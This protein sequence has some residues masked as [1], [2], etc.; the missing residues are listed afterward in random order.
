MNPYDFVRLSAGGPERESV[1]L[2]D[3]FAGLSGRIKCTL[4]GYTPIFIPRPRPESASQG[5]ER[6]AMNR[7]RAGA[8]MLP[9]TSLKGVIRNVAEAASASCF[10][11]PDRLVYERSTVRYALPNAKYQRCPDD[12]GRLCP[13]CRLFGV[14]NRGEVFSGNVTV[15][16]GVARDGYSLKSFTLAVLGAPK[17]RHTAFYAQQ[18][19]G[20]AL[21]VA[22]RKFYFH[23]PQGPLERR[24]QDG[25]NKTVEAVMP[26]AVF[27]F[28]LEYSNLHAADLNL[29]LFALALWDDTCHKIGMGK[30][31]G[32]GSAKL[33]IAE[34]TTLNRSARYQ[35]LNGGWGEAMSDAGLVA[36]VD[37]SVAPFRSS[38]APNLQD[39]HR[40]LRWNESAPD[41]IR[42][43]D[44]N[45]FLDHSREPL[46]SAP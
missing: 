12:Q 21:I 19:V 9:G 27:D 5:H 35:T 10:T 38:T 16:D 41:N 28:E 34:V 20:K 44:R 37:A 45:W 13:A 36:W 46:S 7:N 1:I 24:L 18:P 33:R 26:G 29:L 14:L 43:P 3:R 39:L 17:P 8:P 25:Q 23:R 2:H 11:L 31:V 15:H 40:I 30:P 4:T 22:G 6:L 42:Y 32:L